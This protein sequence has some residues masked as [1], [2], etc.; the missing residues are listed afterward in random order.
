MGLRGTVSMRQ[1]CFIVRLDCWI[2]CELH[3][4][5]CLHVEPLV[6]DT[7]A[8]ALRWS[9]SMCRNNVRVSFERAS[10]NC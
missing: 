2:L 9:V 4:C 7:H 3:A 10:C 5:R 8:Y 1:C 6:G